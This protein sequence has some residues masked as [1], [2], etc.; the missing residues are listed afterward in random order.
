MEINIDTK[1][2]DGQRRQ[3]TKR[4]YEEGGRSG[5]TKSDYKDWIQTEYNMKREKEDKIQI[6]NME[7]GIWIQICNM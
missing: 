2:E 7:Y 6:W 1:S 5:S 4:E 3:N